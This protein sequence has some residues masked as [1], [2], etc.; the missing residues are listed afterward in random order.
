MRNGTVQVILAHWTGE[1]IP[2][3]ARIVAVLRCVRCSH[4]QEIIQRG[5]PESAAVSVMMTLKGRHFDPV[6]LDAFL[7]LL[8]KVRQV[9]EEL[10]DKDWQQEKSPHVSGM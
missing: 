5:L 6:T 9:G 10:A 4:T 3:W 1:A 2:E 7:D 8:P